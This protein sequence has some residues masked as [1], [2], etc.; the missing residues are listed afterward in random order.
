MIRY[1]DLLQNDVEILESVLIDQCALPV[2][3]D[4]LRE[5]VLAA[6]FE[7]L[8]GGASADGRPVGALA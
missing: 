2:S 8:S 5:A 1:E 7:R 6:R 3:R 4:R